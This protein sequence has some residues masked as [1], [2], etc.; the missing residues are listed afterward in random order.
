MDDGFLRATKV[1]NATSFGEVLNPSV[2]C[3]T[4]TACKTRTSLKDTPQAK[5][6]SHFFS[7]FLLLHYWM[8]AGKDFHIVTA[9]E[10]GMFI[11]C[12]RQ[13]DCHSLLKGSA[14]NSSSLASKLLITGCY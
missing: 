12:T 3:R 2:P 7:M 13:W 14:N 4:F 1:L 5:F 11:Y 8:A 6:S 9:D 10:S